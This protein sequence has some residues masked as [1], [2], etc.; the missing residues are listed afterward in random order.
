MSGEGYKFRKRKIRKA[1]KLNK[2]SKQALAQSD[3]RG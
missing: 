3:F 2:M 1:V